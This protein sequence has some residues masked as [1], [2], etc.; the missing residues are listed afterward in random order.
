M[1]GMGW[2]GPRLPMTHPN[3]DDDLEATYEYT[4]FYIEPITAWRAWSVC[5]TGNCKCGQTHRGLLLRSI[6][7]PMPWLRKKASRAH[8]LPRWYSSEREAPQSR[9]RHHAPDA[10]HGCGIYSVKEL[11]SARMWGH[12]SKDRLL[13]IGEV[14]VWGQ[15]LQFQDGYMSEYA[16]PVSVYV[17]ENWSHLNDSAKQDF[18]PEMIAKGIGDSYGIDSWVGWPTIQ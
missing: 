12:Y 3:K 2:A 14:Q 10:G 17:P 13:V 5:G 1:I 6:T 16:Y 18:S 15:V 9:S 8:C 7:Y 4:P 11:K